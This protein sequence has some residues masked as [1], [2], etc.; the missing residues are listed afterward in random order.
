LDVVA[1]TSTGGINLFSLASGTVPLSVY[2]NTGSQTA[3]LQEW[4]NSS[5][6][7][8]AAV[9]SIGYFGIG[10]GN[11]MST[12]HMYGSCT[13]WMGLEDGYGN[14]YSQQTI[15]TSNNTL[16]FQV[17]KEG[18][19]YGDI[20]LNPHGGSVGI[21]TSTPGA[22]L[23]V[24][25]SA[26]TNLQMRIRNN[27]T[28]STSNTAELVL[29]ARSGGVLFDRAK[30]VA[31]SVNTGNY[32]TAMDFQTIDGATG[33][34]TSR[35]Y[36]DSDGNVGVNTASPGASLHAACQTSSAKGL[37][38]QGAA[39][40]TA[41]LTEWQDSS[42]TVLA[43]VTYNG[44]VYSGVASGD[45][46]VG[47]EC[48]QAN[49]AIQARGSGN[50]QLR[51]NSTSGAI[52]KMQAIGN[53]FGLVGTETNHP[54]K[55]STNQNACVY[56]DTTGYV[57]VGN[58]AATGQLETRASSASTKAFIARAA[59]SQTANLTEW[60]DSSG[61]AL[62][63][64]DKNGYICVPTGS[65]APATNPTSGGGLYYD[66]TGNALYAWNGSA[67]KSVNLT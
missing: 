56:F 54:F 48:G 20:L 12:L 24:F 47:I 9:N 45:F 10:T 13:F 11:P 55:L 34:F 59:V 16:T 23:D 43:G 51:A 27:K 38:V 4:K 53:S 1:I 17:V 14:V 66:T 64:V 2:A 21:G 40:Q 44:I 29:A 52:S 49:A 33:V 46:G 57:G 15:D 62:S 60:Q 42:G 61:T 50:P 26:T 32:R 7:V 41:D 5:G 25:D 18:I 28:D 8:R 58:F 3:N 22:K 63:S 65:G 30:I 19:E 6:S 36:I 31:K 35:L 67:W 37:I 39:S